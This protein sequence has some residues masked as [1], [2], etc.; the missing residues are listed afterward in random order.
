[1]KKILIIGAHGM[2]GHIINQY[3]TSLNKYK[4]Y[5]L[6]RDSKFG[7]ADYYCDVEQ[8]ID[9]L[10]WLI[11]EENH[12]DIV[13]NC[14]GLL[15]QPSNENPTKAIYLNS[16]LPHY[17]ESITKNNNTKIIHLSTD[18]IFDGTKGNH[19]ETDKPTEINWY[20]RSKALGEINNNKDLTLRLSIIGTELK[21]DGIGLLNW[22]LNQAGEVNGFINVYWNGI[23]TLELAKQIDRIIE[24]KPQ[25][26]GIYHLSPDFKINKFDLLCI[27]NNVW[28]KN[29]TIIPKSDFYQDKTLINFRKE[30]Y[31]PQIIDY[32]T[33]LKELYNFIQCIK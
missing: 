13:I 28:N 2:A 14:I 22:F 32:K 5:T 30:E 15:N 9:Y 23:T 21:K 17:L 7:I 26:S 18:C 20:G 4:I 3:L 19:S 11:N 25:L 31:N 24:E 8:Y 12:F 16:Y 33:Q 29:I 6:T 1:M 10:D 27:I